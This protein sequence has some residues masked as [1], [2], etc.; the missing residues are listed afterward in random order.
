MFNLMVARKRK[1]LTQEQL[2][3]LLKVDRI[4]ISRWERGEVKPNIYKLKRIAEL[5]EVTTDNLLEE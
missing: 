3:K 2:A 1:K 4:T 5:L